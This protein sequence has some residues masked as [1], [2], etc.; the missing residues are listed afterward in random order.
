M[1]S[2]RTRLQQK[3]LSLFDES[4]LTQIPVQPA[5]ESDGLRVPPAQMEGQTREAVVSDVAVS[6]AAVSLPLRLMEQVVARR[7]MLSALERVERNKGAAGVD[8]MGTKDLRAHLRTHWPLLKCALLEGAYRPQAVRRVEIPKPDGS[9]RMLGIPTVLDRLVQQ[10]LL[11]QA[12]LQVLTPLFDPHFSPCSY[13]FR[14][15]CRGTDAVLKA[16]EH[17]REGFSWTVDLDLEKFFDRVNYDML[18]ARVA[19]R[20][21]GGDKHILLLIRRFLRSGVL[22]NGVSVCNE[23]GTPQGGPLSPLLAN[24]L[25][26]DFDKELEQRGHRF[27]RYA[28]D[29][30]IYVGSL[31]AGERVRRSLTHYLKHRLRLTVNQSKSA[32]ARP[33]QR[34]FLGFSLVAKDQ[35]IRLAPETVKKVKD[36]IRDRTQ[37]KRAVSMDER[38]QS[39]NQYLRGWLGYFALAETPWVFRELASWLRRRL[40]MCQWKDWK[41]P[42]TRARALRALG[43]RAEDARSAAG[44]SRGYWRMAMSRP[45]HKA[46]SIRYWN[47]QGLINLGDRHQRLRKQRLS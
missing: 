32:V 11:Q 31:R 33:W 42:C 26:D 23:E 29:C 39:L 25:L 17:V 10:A 9:K 13:G 35:R 36:K 47:A 8:G 44:V 22:V 6:V 34:K 1:R 4:A 3:S 20:V 40:R 43:L 5:D 21:G 18:M 12:L 30:N 41:Q 37:R 7:N 2:R 24:I 14:P 28:D 19:R 45:L 38:I 46:M 27:V 16:R 15:G